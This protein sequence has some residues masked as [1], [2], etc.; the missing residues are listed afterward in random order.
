[1]KLMSAMAQSHEVNLTFGSRNEIL[2]LSSK[3]TKSI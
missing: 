2:I 1:M 3:R